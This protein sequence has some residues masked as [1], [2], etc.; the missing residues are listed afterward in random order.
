[1]GSCTFLYTT[2]HFSFL[3]M[4]FRMLKRDIGKS[5]YSFYNHFDKQALDSM[6]TIQVPDTP[7][8][9]PPNGEQHSGPAIRPYSERSLTGNYNYVSAI[10]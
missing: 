9:L 10:L 4:H 5:P 8:P 7:C 3:T 6:A 1:M 2:T